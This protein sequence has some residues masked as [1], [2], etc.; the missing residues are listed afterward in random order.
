M[1][2]TKIHPLLM[3]EMNLV[4]R[5]LE[6]DELAGQPDMP[7]IV[8]LKPHRINEVQVLASRPGFDV[9]HELKLISSLSGSAS[10]EEIEAL[11]ESD[12]VE[13]IW[14]DE[15][16][17]AILD[18][19]LSLIEVPRIWEKGNEGK[20]VRIAI[21]DT[22]IDADHP[23]FAGR[24]LGT[25]D[26]TGEGDGDGHGHGTHVASTA[27]GSGAASNGSYR[28]VAPQAEI[29]AAKVLRSDG[30][31]RMSLVIAGMEWAIE[32][33]AQIINLSLGSRGNCDG[34]DATSA[35]SDMAVERGFFVVAAAGNEGPERGTLS[36]PGCARTVITVG[37]STDDDKIADFS[38]RG[39]T[40][41]GRVKPDVVLPGAGIVAARAKGT[42]LGQPVNDR[43]TSMD[44]T[45]MATPHAAGLIALMLVENPALRPA[46]VKRMLMEAVRSLGVEE[47]M[48]GK[49]RV[50]ASR[51][52]ELARAAASPTPAPTPT[53]APAP[54]PQPQGTPEAEGCLGAIARLFGQR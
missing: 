41:D 23:D 50:I 45:S 20:G 46:D 31:G 7:I 47:V 3:E 35:A 10:R 53:P 15:P 34:T 5:G 30:S 18:K 17:Y 44:G 11:S 19:S 38:S 32:E 43:Y 27:A 2:T 26:F 36:S 39:P 1:D 49:G 8:R 54:S 14:Y 22:G 25:K 12:M 9:Q 28:G 52:V 42:S 6:A 24:I 29:L 21:V 13:Y 16:V 33:S 37:A 40:K 48:Q 4:A 51:A